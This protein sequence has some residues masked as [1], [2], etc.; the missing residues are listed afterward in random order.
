MTSL[1]ELSLFFIKKINKIKKIMKKNVKHL[2]AGVEKVTQQSSS[3]QIPAR[4]S[5]YKW[6]LTNI[7]L[8]TSRYIVTR[9]LQL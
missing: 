4:F 6:I 8:L 3:K 9:K 2:T 7:Y 1:I 5:I